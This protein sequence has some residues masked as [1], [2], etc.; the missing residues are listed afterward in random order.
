[1][2]TKHFILFQF[3]FL[4]LLASCHSD[5]KQEAVQSVTTIRIDNIDDAEDID[6]TKDK[7]VKPRIRK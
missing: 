1:M 3:V 6:V 7:Y 5:K 2:R 4:L